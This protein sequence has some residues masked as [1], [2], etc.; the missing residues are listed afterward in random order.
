[1]RGI[2]MAAGPGEA[3]GRET[4]SEPRDGGGP[5]T[6]DVS[7]AGNG[8]DAELPAS[9]LSNEVLDLLSSFQESLVG[10]L[11]DQTLKAA[12]RHPPASLGLSGGVACN[13]RLREA[14]R[15]AGERLGIPV[16]YPTPSLTTDNA[17]MIASAGYHHLLQDRR[18]SLSLNADP[19][20]RLQLI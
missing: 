5:A 15:L 13:S 14:M 4:A 6:T 11:V 8:G 19:V 2:R 18:A 17:A 12:R 1:S 9:E 10:Y 7:A 16:F 20:A 3:G